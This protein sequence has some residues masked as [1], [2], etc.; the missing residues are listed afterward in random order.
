MKKFLSCGWEIVQWLSVTVVL[1]YSIAWAIAPPP[2]NNKP[3]HNFWEQRMKETIY[4][5]AGT[6]PTTYTIKGQEVTREEIIL[7]ISDKWIQSIKEG[8]VDL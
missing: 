4:D 7:Y 5:G 6:V 2:P 3:T 1:V 8:T